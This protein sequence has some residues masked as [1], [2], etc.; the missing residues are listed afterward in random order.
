MAAVFQSER[1]FR[2]AWPQISQAFASPT[3]A[4]SD[5]EWIV[6]VAAPEAGRRILDAPCGFG[7]HSI[8]LARR[9]F[10][11]TG[12][13]FSETELDRARKAATEAG[14]PLR[15][16]CQDIRDMEF[17]GEFDLAVNLFSSIGYF[18]DDGPP[19]DRSILARAPARRRLRPRY[20]ESRSASEVAAARGAQAGR[21]LDAPHLERV[22]SRDEPLARAVVA[23]QARGGEVEGGRGGADRGE[24]DPPLLRPRALGDA[25]AGALGPGGALRRARRH[26]L[27]AGRPAPGSR[28]PQIVQTSRERRPV[29]WPPSRAPWSCS[30]ARSIPTASRS[31]RG[32]RASSSATMR[33]RPG[34]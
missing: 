20:P 4:A 13:D 31:S 2:E 28:R 16:V 26:A 11:V 30:L 6:G 14:V 33:P 21:R 19:G 12:V 17:P 29:R 24:R 27:L 15:L 1:F 7:R 9:G 23:P 10:Q 3:D 32:R 18:S 5:V 34:S 8:E 22:R 25:A